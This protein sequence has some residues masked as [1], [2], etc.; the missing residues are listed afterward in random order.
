MCRLC[1]LLQIPTFFSSASQPDFHSL[2]HIAVLYCHLAKALGHR[3]NH[4]YS[5]ADIDERISLCRDALV[6]FNEHSNQISPVPAM[7]TL[8]AALY[9]RFTVSAQQNDL[10]EAFK[11]LDSAIH[12]C[13]L[14]PNYLVDIGNVL[15]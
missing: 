12:V 15:M 14:E 13:P 5:S 11:L 10:L 6:F 2:A 9:T 8:G 4:S 7:A 1:T 3:Y